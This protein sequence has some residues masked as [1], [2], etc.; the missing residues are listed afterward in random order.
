MF[1]LPF[2]GT[3]WSPWFAIIRNNHKLCVTLAPPRGQPLFLTSYLDDIFEFRNFDN[4]VIKIDAGA[5]VVLK[6][7]GKLRFKYTGP[8]SEFTS[9]KSFEPIGIT[10]GTTKPD[11]NHR[12]WEPANN[13]V[14]QDRQFLYNIDNYDIRHPYCMF[15]DVR[16]NLHVT[17]FDEF[18]V[19]KIKYFI[20]IRTIIVEIK[21]QWNHT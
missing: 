12:L 2:L 1:V 6:H 20:S 3:F 7:A 16:D 4:S 15:V 9:E 13:I 18:N 14:Y 11:S 21:C 8:D 17:K 5:V 10:T 19:K